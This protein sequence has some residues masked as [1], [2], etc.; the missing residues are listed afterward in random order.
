MPL[1]TPHNGLQLSICKLAGTLSF[2]LTINGKRVSKSEISDIDTSVKEEI[3]IGLGTL[4]TAVGLELFL[5]KNDGTLELEF[6]GDTGGIGNW[7]FKGLAQEERIVMVAAAGMQ[8]ESAHMK[9][10]EMQNESIA[11][12]ELG[13]QTETVVTNEMKIQMHQQ[14]SCSVGT[15]TDTAAIVKEPSTGKKRKQPFQPYIANKR[16]RSAKSSDPWPK[17]LYAECSRKTPDFKGG[18]GL[19]HIDLENGKVWFEGVYGTSKYTECLEKKQ[20]DLRDTS[21]KSPSVSLLIF[22][23]MKQ[24]YAKYFHFQDHDHELRLGRD[25]LAK[26]QKEIFRIHRNPKRHAIWGNNDG[27]A[28]KSDEVRFKD[29]TIIVDAI[30]HCIDMT[31]GRAPVHDPSVKAE[32]EEKKKNHEAEIVLLGNRSNEK[33][34][35]LGVIWRRLQ[36][37][38]I[39]RRVRYNKLRQYVRS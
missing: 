38:E 27:S 11:T 17:H 3:P 14:V 21:S 25:T 34:R 29:P 23:H 19:L 20:V 37:I 2:S 6:L 31:S 18:D 13:M 33:R 5:I 1:L 22:P 30:I 7:R 35:E 26:A 24:A 10:K 32:F 28:Y 9:E 4:V 15:Q 12:Q 36:M 8:A 39:Q 16:A